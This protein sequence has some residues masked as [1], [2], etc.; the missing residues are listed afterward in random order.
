MVSNV[1][2][3]AGP[4]LYVAG[5]LGTGPRGV[6]IDTMNTAFRVAGHV[7]SDLSNQSLETKLGSAGLSSK[8]GKGSFIIIKIV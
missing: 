7:V 8:L 6:I 5:W 2:G 1:D 4:G 3:R